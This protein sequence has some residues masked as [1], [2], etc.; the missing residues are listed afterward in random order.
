[1]SS[2]TLKKDYIWNTVGVLLQNAISPLLLIA[3]TRINGIEISGLFSYAFA[4]SIMLFAFGLWGGRTYQV[5]DSKRE[6]DHRSYI[7]ARTL[8]AAGMIIAAIIFCLLNEYDPYKTGVIMILVVYK[9]IESIADSIYGVLQ[10]HDNLRSAGK[11]LFYKSVLGL[12]LFIIVDIF[13]GNLI[14]SSAAIV[15]INILFVIF[16]DIRLASKKEDLRIKINSLKYFSMQGL[17]ILN[18]TV[19]I[20]AVTFLATFSINIPR[21][22]IDRFD[23]N[24]IGYF[25]II[26]VP[27]TL[28]A[29][30]MSFILQPNIIHLSTLF[31]NAQYHRFKKIIYNV[32]T[33]TVGFGFFVALTTYFIGVPL[34]NVFFGV[35]FALHKS[36]LMVMILGGIANAIVA[37]YIIIFT[38]VRKFK[39][40]FYTLLI[41]NAF[42]VLLSYVF[43]QQYGIL[44][45][46]SLYALINILQVFILSIVYVNSL[47][48][49]QRKSAAVPSKP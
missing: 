45:G 24:E 25:G 41:T 46:V 49:T 31:T 35:D 11:S 39:A 14:L 43:V 8:L 47:K 33:V 10:V 16:Y 19:A 21:F 22:F 17:V 26:A 6:F 4:I 38:I 20:F 13:T 32:M 27:I 2:T 3:I 5:S 44:G 42:L 18:R 29:V 30:F 15:M 28:I 40:L 34:L 23:S 48:N 1:M 36:E 9:A 12:M 7:V 37:I